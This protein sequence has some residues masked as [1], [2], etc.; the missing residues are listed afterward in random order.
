MRQTL[1][2]PF[3]DGDGAV[4]LTVSG[5][6]RLRR[7]SIA[8]VAAGARHRCWTTRRRLLGLAD[9]IDA[10]ALPV[11]LPGLPAVL[12][13]DPSTSLPYGVLRWPGGS[14]RVVLP[15]L[16]NAARSTARS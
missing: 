9:A 5:R 15:P 12:E 10:G 2:D 1:S 6:W 7:R 14:A 13:A 4:V 8:V 11:R 3:V 16:A